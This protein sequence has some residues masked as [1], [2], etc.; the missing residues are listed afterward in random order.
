MKIP[1]LFPGPDREKLSEALDRLM[2][3][4]EANAKETQSWTGRAKFSGDR[5]GEIA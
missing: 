5:V 3:E 2:A 1:A 4:I